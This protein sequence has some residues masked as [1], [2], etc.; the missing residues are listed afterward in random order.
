MLLRDA[1]A[2]AAYTRRTLKPTDRLVTRPAEHIPI[3][4]RM[5]A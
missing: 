2:L 1:E 3:A 4:T 5:F